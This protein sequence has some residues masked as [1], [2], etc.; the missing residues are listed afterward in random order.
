[1]IKEVQNMSDLQLA[2]RKLDLLI[3]SGVDLD[4]SK[5]IARAWATM[6]KTSYQ[7]RIARQKINSLKKAK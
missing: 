1:M 6:G 4:H 3:K 7:T 5:V 2:C